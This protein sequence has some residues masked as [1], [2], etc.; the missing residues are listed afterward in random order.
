MKNNIPYNVLRNP[1]DWENSPRAEAIVLGIAGIPAGTAAA[2]TFLGSTLGSVSVLA[3]STV[4]SVATSAIVSAL[5][6]APPTPKQSILVN[7]REAAAPQEIVYGETRKG[8][9][10][11]YYETTRGGS[12]LFQFITVAAHEV[13]S[14][15][16]IYVNDKEVTLSPDGYDNGKRTGAGWVTDDGLLT[17][18]LTHL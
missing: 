18:L 4:L 2:T 12:V 10:V 7:A 6:P 1:N 5:T 8:G 9:I 3:V 11:T 16:A 17:L 15:D 13:E 14:I